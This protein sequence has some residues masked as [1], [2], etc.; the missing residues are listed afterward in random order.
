[1][2]DFTDMVIKYTSG[3]KIKNRHLNARVNLHT[4]IGL[5]KLYDDYSVLIDDARGGGI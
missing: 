1:M 3:S 4:S 5:N 2:T